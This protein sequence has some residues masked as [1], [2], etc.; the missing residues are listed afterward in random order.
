MTDEHS[1]SKPW[2]EY[3]AYLIPT[4]PILIYWF[5]W[6]LRRNYWFTAD[7]A[8][9]Y[10]FDSLAIFAGK[11]YVYVDHPGTPV[12]IIGTMLL[13]LTYPF[14]DGR[15][16]LIRYYIAEPETFFILANLF[17]LTANL[18]TV[19]IFF[20]TVVSTLK[21]DKML[22]GI[23]LSLMYFAIH[24]SSFS[25]LTY[26]THN[27]FNLIFGTLWLLWLYNELQ[28]KNE[29]TRKKIILLGVTVGVI[30]TTQL[31]LIPW[32]AG[33]VIT[34]F[35]YTLRKAKAFS[36]AIIDSLIMLGSGLMG[37]LLMLVPVY[38]EVPRLLAW[39]SRLIGRDGLY[40]AGEPNIY[41]PGLIAASLRYWWQNIPL[42]MLALT[43]ILLVFGF[44]AWRIR[45]QA[46][47]RLSAGDFALAVGLLFQT[48]ILILVLSK[49][50]YRIRYV[51]S[52]AA[53]L[54]VLFLLALKLLEQVNWRGAGLKRAMYAGLI[55]SCL[56]F[57]S[58][59]IAAQQRNKT[60]ERES[61]V[62]HSQ[63]VSR[64]A[65]LKGV[66]EDEVVTVYA[67]GTPFKCAGL[68]MANNVTRAF[69]SEVREQCPNQHAIYDFG[70]E[71]ELNLLYPIASIEE[72][73]WDLVVW[74]GNGS[75][76]PEYLESVGG[77][78][79]PTSWHIRRG[80]WFYIHSEMLL[81]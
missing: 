15:E 42:V 16:A 10:F 11:T 19:A 70:F 29:L 24:P 52:L 61:A 64:L 36:Q 27:S 81:E 69:D 26:W 53:I 25:S 73:N 45:S 31:Y 34:I 32:L 58:Q 28:S 80:K 5:S 47:R 14:F 63:V 67:F 56:F 54:P 4:L 3:G 18:L 23:A 17:L 74:P 37:I 8:A 13:G 7:P 59:E 20:R 1:E 55:I 78:T 72:I 62:A 33:G 6:L 46:I 51:L 50:F 48:L 38:R 66:P 30:V 68:L 41:S 57:M 49:M 75:N 22:A 65:K 9:L 2:R 43:I 60:V 21:Q 79:I 12:N 77:Q 39:L 71:V 44:I 76:L 35:M 40:G